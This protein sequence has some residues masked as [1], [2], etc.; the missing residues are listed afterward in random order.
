MKMSKLICLILFSAALTLPGRIAAADD[1]K[2]IMDKNGCGTC[3]RMEGPAAKTFEEAL[4]RKAPD[5]FYAGSKFQETFLLE[6]LQK[7]YPIRPAGAFFLNHVKTVDG[8]DMIQ[9][10]PLCAS[11]LSKEDAEAASKYLMTLKDQ[12]METGVYKPGASY[13]KIGAKMLFTKSV[14]CIGCHQIKNRDKVEGGTSGSSLYNAGARLNGD[15]LSSYIR[16]PQYWDPMSP[17]PKWD[18]GEN[19]W[20]Q[21]TS[22]VM[23]MKE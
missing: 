16:N 3:H 15:W 19:A 10:P 23:E 20:M 8:K 5:L 22:Y 6:F 17:M 1:G 7:P 14:A 11:R 4:K 18:L 9:D 13:F 2:N 12:A 21:L